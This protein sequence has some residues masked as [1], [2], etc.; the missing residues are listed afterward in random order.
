[1]MDCGEAIELVKTELRIDPSHR[2]AMEK[3]QAPESDLFIY[4]T[5]IKLEVTLSRYM[6][7]AS[8]ATKFNELSRIYEQTVQYIAV[9]YQKNQE[10]KK[11]PP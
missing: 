2:A 11:C 10:I 9:C 5:N 4:L 8:Q 3:G 1:M 7:I 6:I